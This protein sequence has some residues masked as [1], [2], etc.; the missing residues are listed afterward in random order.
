[1]ERAFCD[2]VDVWCG[3]ENVGFPS[4]RHRDVSLS[5]G[6]DFSRCEGGST[7]RLVSVVVSEWGCGGKC[8]SFGGGSTG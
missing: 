5:Y 2:D 7:D 1:M 6:V 3:L 8:C 4:S